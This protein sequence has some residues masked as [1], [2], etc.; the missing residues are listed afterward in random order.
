MII[1]SLD[2][3]LLWPNYKGY[4]VNVHEIACITYGKIGYAEEKIQ[5]KKDSRPLLFGGGYLF[6]KESIQTVANYIK[7]PEIIICDM[8][9]RNEWNRLRI[10]IQ[11]EAFTKECTLASIKEKISLRESAISIALGG[12]GLIPEK[13]FGHYEVKLYKDTSIIGKVQFAYVPHIQAAKH[14]NQKGIYYQF[15]MPRSCKLNFEDGQLVSEKDRGSDYRI[16][17]WKFTD[18]GQSVE[19]KLTYTSN[20][21]NVI[22][23]RIDKQVRTISWGILQLS[24]LNA[25][26]W[27]NKLAAVSL[28]N[29]KNQND[30]YLV[31]EGE[32]ILKSQSISLILE[33]HQKQILKCINGLRCKEKATRMRIHLAE[34]IEVLSGKNADDCVLKLICKYDL[35]ENEYR[36]ICFQEKLVLK[37]LKCIIKKETM[38][39]RWEQEGG[40]NQREFLIYPIDRPWE[41]VIIKSIP[42]GK[43]ELSIDKNEL[44]EGRYGILVRYEKDEWGFEEEDKDYQL[45]KLPILTLGHGITYEPM[46]KVELYLHQMITSSSKMVSQSLSPK[47]IEK[48][49]LNKLLKTLIIIGE[50][51]ENYKKGTLEKVIEAV[52]SIIVYHLEEY[53]KFMLEAQLPRER[54]TYYCQAFNVYNHLMIKGIDLSTAQLQQLWKVSPMLGMLVSLQMKE[55]D[56]EYA[57]DK[58]FSYVGRQG[59][60]N[61]IAKAYDASDCNQE[62]SVDRQQ[63]PLED[64]L[65]LSLWQDC[66]CKS[67]K[68]ALSQAIIGD[69]E[70]LREYFSH[71]ASTWEV[72]YRKKR[73]AAMQSQQIL[74]QNQK[75]IFMGKTYLEVV[76]EMRNQNASYIKQVSDKVHKI[77]GIRRTAI[78]EFMQTD[79]HKKVLN[80]LTKRIDEGQYAEYWCGIIA[81]LQACESLG[82]KEN[83]FTPYQSQQLTQLLIEQMNALYERDRIV[84]Q[85]YLLMEG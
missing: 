23:F 33:D 7:L 74:T 53:F 19:G 4:R 56:R 57:M 71:A 34:F 28:E 83:I 25:F 13:C 51:L 79:K 9:P 58:I 1:E 54:F 27:S 20:T 41:D 84:F 62:E 73:R 16:E 68:P 8:L 5:V 39:F 85:I 47:V 48:Q 66:Y 14:L 2:E 29:L 63:H 31:V 65:K 24:N 21:G 36:I 42:D 40:L 55:I 43:S 72:A 64:C 35:Y 76:M 77:L 10:V 61:L 6:G 32:E 70:E 18:V 44:C 52:E 17:L 22:D 75:S 81:Y 69:K 3:L 37:N 82:I 45:G 49:D 38:S 60:K 78:K 46:D 11:G 50:N 80:L 26:K 30:Y 67:I 15:T 59:I 12:E